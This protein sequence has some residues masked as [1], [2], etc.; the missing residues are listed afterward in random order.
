MQTS[1]WDTHYV[2]T[3][4]IVPCIVILFCLC[5]VLDVKSPVKAVHPDASKY[6]APD[7]VVIDL[8][9]DWWSKFYASLQDPQLKQEEYDRLQLDKLVVRLT[10][11]MWC[12]QP[13]PY[14][15]RY[16]Y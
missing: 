13:F 7:G 9:F 10:V 2:T 8:P 15:A 5:P 4:H 3:D 16:R 1:L 11:C 6:L 14:M 12:L